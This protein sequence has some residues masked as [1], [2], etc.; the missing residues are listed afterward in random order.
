[1]RAKER[2][3]DVLGESVPQLLQGLPGHFPLGLGMESLG[4]DVGKGLV[5]LFSLSS[6]SL[7][8]R[9]AGR[10]WS[11]L[12]GGQAVVSRVTEAELMLLHVELCENEENGAHAQGLDAGN[13]ARAVDIRWV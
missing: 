2:G 13:H 7:G 9:E 10:P 5:L 8:R 4:T 11:R 6:R 12:G 1:M 3:P